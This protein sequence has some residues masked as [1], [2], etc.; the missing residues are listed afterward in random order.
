MKVK[1]KWWRSNRMKV[2][3]EWWG[4]GTQRTKLKGSC[5]TLFFH[6]NATLDEICHV[7][8]T[9]GCQPGGMPPKVVNL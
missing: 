1:L 3:L 5:E 9:C 6:P 8:T 4:C 2:K 7:S